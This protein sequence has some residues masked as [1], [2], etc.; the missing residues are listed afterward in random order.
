MKIPRFFIYLYFLLEN[1]KEFDSIIPKLESE[2]RNL[3][4][5]LE[6]KTNIESNNIST[7]NNEIQKFF[8]LFS[9]STILTTP[10]RPLNINQQ[11]NNNN[12][13]NTTTPKQN[14]LLLLNESIN[15]ENSFNEQ[16][17]FDNRK[18]IQN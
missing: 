3:K 17:L 12:N 10:L 9:S 5:K 8:N 4:G 13:N 16:T 1:R 11:Q 18:F 15:K 14:Y 7:T 2:T 6:L